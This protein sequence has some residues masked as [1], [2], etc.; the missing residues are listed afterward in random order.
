LSTDEQSAA[1]ATGDRFATHSAILPRAA[2]GCITQMM[3]VE[4]S[5]SEA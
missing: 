5:N 2:D 1:R 3:L 4:P